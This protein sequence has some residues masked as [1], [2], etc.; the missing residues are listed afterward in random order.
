MVNTTIVSRVFLLHRIFK[1][2]LSFL[3]YVHQRELDL[4]DIAVKYD[5][6]Y[7]NTIF[8]S[9]NQLLESET[10]DPQVNKVYQD[11]QKIIQTGKENNKF[12]IEFIF[13]VFFNFNS[14][15]FDF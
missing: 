6:Y 14:W 9:D 5:G 12:P 3:E 13:D 7:E 11:L 2:M 1:D 15:F 4:D 10:L 8:S